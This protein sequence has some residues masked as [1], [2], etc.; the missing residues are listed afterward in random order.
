MDIHVAR[1][2]RQFG[3]Y[4]LE[5]VRRQLAAGTLLPTDFAW[6]VGA[7]GWVPLASFPGLTPPPP[8]SAPPGG[9]S[10]YPTSAGV[11][12]QS[13]PATSG[14]AVAS[15][16]FAI[17]SYTVVPFLGAIVAVICGHVARGEIRRASG[18]M[19]GDGLAVA[20]L[21]IGYIN[22]AILP[23]IIAVA[24]L[25]G[26]AL[27]VVSMVQLKAKEAQSESNARQIVIA[28]RAYAVDHHDAFPPT[29]EELVPRYLPDRRTL[30]CPLS[31]GEAV[32]YIYFGGTTDDPS[33]KVLLM[34]KYLDDHY[35]VN[36]AGRRIVG[37]VDGSCQLEFEPKGL[38]A[39]RR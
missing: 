12:V 22:L 30:T 36:D 7:A 11:S 21:I 27:P 4:P 33:N 8:G 9:T 29:L 23:L 3:P 15:L 37:H 26:L 24:L 10:P 14:A 34:S 39:P 32:G 6:T 2:G 31:P 13:R 1:D 17:L 38:R 19:T 28:C 25:A 18:A 16:I 5:E 20:G 35:K